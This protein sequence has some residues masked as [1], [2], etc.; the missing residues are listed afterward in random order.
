MACPCSR[1]Q[2]DEEVGATATEVSEPTA[3]SVSPP[4]ETPPSAEIADVA[5]I[6]ILPN[7]E[8]ATETADVEPQQ[9]MATKR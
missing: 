7:I 1:P 9:A 4:P 2:A 6:E 5:E 3:E 8:T